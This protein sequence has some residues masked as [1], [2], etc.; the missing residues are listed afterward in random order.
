VKSS[1]ASVRTAV[2]ITCRDIDHVLPHEC[3]TSLGT[4]SS[5]FHSVAQLPTV[6]IP[7]GEEFS[8]LS[9]HRC[10]LMTC[11]CTNH[12]LPYQRVDQPRHTLIHI[13]SVAKIPIFSLPKGEEL[14]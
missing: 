7:K 5:S 3:S 6:S 8:C 9:S 13:L 2:Q 4:S 14:A 12:L 10:V 11:R 1:P